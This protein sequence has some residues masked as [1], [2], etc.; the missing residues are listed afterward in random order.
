MTIF[1][2]VRKTEMYIYKFACVCKNLGKL[3]KNNWQIIWVSFMGRIEN[4]KIIN[5]CIQF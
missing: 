3:G 2:Y 1:K 5:L 4:K